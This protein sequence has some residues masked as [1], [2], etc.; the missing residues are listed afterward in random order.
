MSDKGKSGRDLDT[1]QRAM[2]NVLLQVMTLYVSFSPA[3]CAAVE[4]VMIATPSQGLFE[5]PVVVAMRNGYFR[6]EG[7]EVRRIQIHP[8]IAVKAL[9]AGEV[10]YVSDWGAS[11]QA[12]MTGAP[13]KL[14]A[15]MVSRPL[16]VL[17]SRPEIRVGRDLKGKTVG[18]DS[19]GS[20]VDYLS[21]VAVRYLGLDPDR[22]V[23]IIDTGESLLRVAALK[24]G[25]ID[26]TAVDVA[27]AVK[28]EEEG[29]KR[30][31]HLGDIIDLPISG[32]A[33]TTAKLATHREQIKKVIQAT[34]RG[35]RFIKQ[36]KPETIRIIQSHLRITLSQATKTYDSATRFFTDDGFVS[37]RAVSLDLRRAKQELQL[38]TEPS[39]SQMTDWSLLREIKLERSKI[40][41]WLKQYEP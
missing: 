14:V 34:L 21:R 25:S 33:L 16:H 30:L 41:Y 18:V 38:V 13:I 15:A 28:A 29:L 39:L 19:F 26:A 32:I 37:Q 27:L 24:D 10:D 2:R 1:V 9:L 11:V 20:R 31:L 3:F 40:P 36:K 8:E 12:A 5:L 17:I 4:Q 23:K 35:T 22:D 6:T 7:L